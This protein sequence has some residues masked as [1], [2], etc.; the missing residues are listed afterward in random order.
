MAW[1]RSEGSAFNHAYL[2]TTCAWTWEAL[3]GLMS[4][5]V[6]TPTF[7]GVCCLVVPIENLPGQLVLDSCILGDDPHHLLP[8]PSKAGILLT[9]EYAVTSRNPING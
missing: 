4:L 9:L 2:E 6:S 1:L 8:P 3:E 5:H 7:Q